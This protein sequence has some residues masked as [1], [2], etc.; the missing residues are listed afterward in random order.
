M[1]RKLSIP[2]LWV[3]MTFWGALGIIILM[4][5]SELVGFAVVIPKIIPEGQ[6]YYMVLFSDTVES[7]G[8]KYFYRAAITLLF[9]W[10]FYSCRARS[11][12]VSRLSVSE[13]SMTLWHAAV[14]AGWFLVLLAS[15]LAVIFISYGWFLKTV[16]PLA[17]SGQS[18]MIA[19]YENFTLHWLMPLA[20][21]PLSLTVAALYL[22]LALSMAVD[23]RLLRRGGHVPMVSGI[24]AAV[25]EVFFSSRNEKYLWMLIA[26]A[27][28][29]AVVQTVRLI[30][31]SKEEDEP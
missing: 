4:A 24:L 29:L 5:A 8:V 12:T 27:V 13:T 15:Q 9:F 28:A 3:S 2:A 19:F 18:L 22:S 25:L 11:A 17:V 6:K 14:I 20:D 31:S 16:D 23:C 7:V 1:K 26:V 10:I 21:W 30:K